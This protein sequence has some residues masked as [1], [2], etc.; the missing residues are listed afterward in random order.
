MLDRT[1]GMTEI[2]TATEAMRI[3]DSNNPFAKKLA[4]LTSIKRN[5]EDLVSSSVSRVKNKITNK[6]KGFLS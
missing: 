6:I 1:G 4:D 2:V 5:F 3:I